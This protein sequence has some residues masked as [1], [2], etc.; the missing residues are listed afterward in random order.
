MC[1]PSPTVVQL[2]LPNNTDVQ[3]VKI[4][5]SYPY[6]IEIERRMIKLHFLNRFNYIGFQSMHAGICQ[7]SVD[8]LPWMLRSISWWHDNNRFP[9]IDIQKCWKRWNWK[10]IFGCRNFSSTSSVCF[11]ANFQKFVQGNCWKSAKCISIFDHWY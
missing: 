3:Q 7:I 9:V 1:K 10:N 4:W 5:I 8:A 6:L 11:G 2:P